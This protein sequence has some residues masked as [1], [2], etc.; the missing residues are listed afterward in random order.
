MAL[1]LVGLYRRQVPANRLAS[2][3]VLSATIIGLVLF[4]IGA[5][6]LFLGLLEPDT[7]VSGARVGWSSFKGA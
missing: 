4:T 1:A 3:L 5:I 7:S 2:D 6:T